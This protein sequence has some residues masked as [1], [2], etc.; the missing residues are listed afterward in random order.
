MLTT[1]TVVPRIFSSSVA[2]ILAETSIVEPDLAII[3]QNRR[4]SFSKRG[5]EGAPDVV[6]E[7]LS[8]IT[9]GN[10]VFLK[11]AA[12]A[13]LG[14]PEYWIVDP[15]SKT[16][17]LYQLTG[18]GKFEEKAILEEKGIAECLVLE[19]LKINIEELFGA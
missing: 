7:I 12:Y 2:R 8:P 3:R 14:V 9:R 6:V 15:G 4:E 5:F 18:A 16:V 13:R 11:K 17:Y 19:G 1:T 10:D